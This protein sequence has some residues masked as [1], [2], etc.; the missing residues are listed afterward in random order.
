LLN[1]ISN[2]TKFYHKIDL[3]K[4]T[5][6]SEIGTMIGKIVIFTF[7]VFLM[8]FAIGKILFDKRPSIEGRIDYFLKGLENPKL[9]YNLNLEELS[10]NHDYLTVEILNSTS[11]YRRACYQILPDRLK[12]VDDCKN[13]LEIILDEHAASSII[14]ASYYP[15]NTLFSEF[16]FSHIKIVGFKFRD[17]LAILK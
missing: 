3:N 15:Q 16:I 11:V 8:F 1:P 12:R 13:D 2:N 14:S 7:L 9:P 5:I 17:V 6:K 4:F 10:K